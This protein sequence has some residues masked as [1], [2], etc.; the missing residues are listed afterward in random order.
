LLES[1]RAFALKE[2]G[3]RIGEFDLAIAASARVEGRT[4]VTHDA[5][6]Q[7]VPGLEVEDWTR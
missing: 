3:R 1:R 5:D 7:K 2:A 4:V 6:F